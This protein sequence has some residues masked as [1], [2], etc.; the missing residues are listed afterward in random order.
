MR[1]VSGLYRGRVLKSP[2]DFRTRP[3]SD[4]L[5][6]TLFNILAQRINAETKFLDLCA[7]T[8]AVGIEALSRGAAISFFVEQALPIS[9]LIEDNLTM[10]KVDRERFRIIRQDASKFVETGTEGFDIVFFDPPYQFDY[11]TVLRSIGGVASSLLNPGGILVAEHSTKN[12][13]ENT[14]EKLHRVR[15]V[16]AGAST[17]SFY[18]K[19]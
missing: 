12:N 10:L 3:T 16:K 4:R 11:L 2:P 8:G 6:E 9:K 1:I 17:L 14:I 7:G 13:L 18:E 15:S 19:E 5:R